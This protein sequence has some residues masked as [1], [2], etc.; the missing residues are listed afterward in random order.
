MYMRVLFLGLW[1]MSNAI[2]C[3]MEE[4]TLAL[5]RGTPLQQAQRN[6][7]SQKL[8]TAISQAR[9]D[10]VEKIILDD[11]LIVRYSPDALFV[12]RAVAIADYDQ[13][14]L[15]LV[16]RAGGN[17][18]EVN[19]KDGNTPAHI[20]A[21][22]LHSEALL[23]LHARN[24]DLTARNHAGK[25]PADHILNGGNINEKKRVEI[26]DWFRRHGIPVRIHMR[27]HVPSDAQAQYEQ[28]I[29][30]IDAA[31]TVMGSTADSEQQNAILSLLT[32][33]GINIEEI[34][35]RTQ[36][37]MNRKNLRGLIR[38]VNKY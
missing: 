27:A 30:L 6:I 23:C 26:A 4:N 34:Q 15:S 24:A 38:Q 16:L 9:F 32:K 20:A 19:P 2:T 36:L 10:D 17:P 18:N 28:R 5:Y 22:L 8:C 1:L 3:A 35:Q 37:P 29:R 13:R 21:C 11:P 31:L 25:A 7:A 14:I 12:S 33:Q